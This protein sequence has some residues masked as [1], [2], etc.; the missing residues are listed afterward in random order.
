MIASSDGEP[1]LLHT[2]CHGEVLH[3]LYPYGLVC[4]GEGGLSAGVRVEARKPSQLTS[5][6]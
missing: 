2:N 6:E 1:K 3:A 5:P 4:G